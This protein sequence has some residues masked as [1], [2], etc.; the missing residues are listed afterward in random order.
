M[1]RIIDS[2]LVDDDGANQS[3]ELDKRVPLAPLRARRD[4]SIAST[5]PTCRSQIAESSRSNRG[6]AIPPPDLPKSSSMISTLLHPSCW[7]DQQARIAGADSRDC[8][9]ADPASL[10]GYRHMLCGVNA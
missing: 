7:H 6:R 9:P 8:A 4:A 1:T 2:I 5:A 3:T 10:G